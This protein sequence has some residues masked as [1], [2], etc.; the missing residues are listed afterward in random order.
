MITGSDAQRILLSADCPVLSVK[1]ASGQ[2]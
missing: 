2:V 1:A